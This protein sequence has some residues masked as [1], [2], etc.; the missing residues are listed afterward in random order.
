M[1]A[2]SPSDAIA[3][4]LD[5][6]RAAQLPYGEFK[7]LVGTR[8]S[9]KKGYFESAP[10]VTSFIVNALALFPRDDV[11]DMLDKALD[12]MSSEQDLGG[13]WRYW[14]LRDHKHFRLPPDLDDT[15]CISFALQAAGRRPPDNLWAFRYARDD[16]GRFLTWLT[17]S[18]RRLFS[19]RF[20]M[21]HA[22]GR[23]REAISQ[24]TADPNQVEDS[25]FA[26]ARLNLGDVDPVV[27]ANVVLYLG[28]RSET[29]AAI[30]YLSQLVRDGLPE[31]FSQ[32][33]KEPLSLYYVIA[34]C[35]RHASP[36]FADLK[37]PIIEGVLARIGPD[38][39]FENVL[40]AAVAASVLMSFDPASPAIPLAIDQ[41]LR[42]QR[43]HGAWAPHIFYNVYGS[44][45][46]TTSFC[47]EALGLYQ[48]LQGG[49]AIRSSNHVRRPGLEKAPQ[50]PV[51]FIY[52]AREAVWPGIVQTLL[53]EGGVVRATLMECDAIVGAK[54]G[55]SMLDMF[56]AER[57]APEY[58]LEPVLASVQIAMTAG[59]R[60]RGIEPDVIGARCG[61][62]FAAAYAAGR[63]SLDDALEIACRLSRLIRAGGIGGRMIALPARLD[64]VEALRRES[65]AP[66]TIAADDAERNTIISC[67]EPHLPALLSFLE[68]SGAAFKVLG[69]GVAYH[70]AAVDEWR[71]EFI[72]PLDESGS[73]LPLRPLY[74]ATAGGWLAAG[75][76]NLLHYWSVIRDPAFVAPMFRA[77]FQ[78]GHR[79]F[80]EIGD[81]PLRGMI[82]EQA[83]AVGVGV[84]VLASLRRGSSLAMTMSE[85]IR[86]LADR[87]RGVSPVTA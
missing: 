26:V 53:A 22:L 87:D 13:V 44:E 85:A 27:N 8:K 75:D 19:P 54:L 86:V 41:I 52:S 76:S 84:N 51:A 21:I 35:R 81:Q 77:M 16:R 55:W 3:R 78:D 34:R 12:F 18:R 9:L 32:Y 29:A 28:E 49:P 72:A 14:G 69:L 63:L 66:F 56:P 39:Q 42:S 82:E 6:L 15:A 80:I 46:F 74:S 73:R 5:F 20:W 31:D 11:G 2:G 79:T 50:S 83:E 64:E 62:E 68:F 7:T 48:Q 17:P 4:G 70:N 65:P 10:F 1:T 47:L 43:D 25:R 61:G 33:Y 45:E 38:G 23:L 30:E 24:L 59:W 37:T 57:R 40:W 60:H 36:V 58:A 71:S 67:A